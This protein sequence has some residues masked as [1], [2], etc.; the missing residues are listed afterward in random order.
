MDSLQRFVCQVRL[1]DAAGSQLGCG[2]IC[3]PRHVLTCTHVV[4]ACLGVPASLGADVSARFPLAPGHVASLQVRA[5]RPMLDVQRAETD[6]DQLHDLCLLELAKG[7]SFP[8]QAAAAIPKRGAIED[9]LPIYAL[10]L[11][12]LTTEEGG[13]SADIGGVD[14]KGE[15]GGYDSLS[16]RRLHSGDLETAVRHGCSGTAAFAAGGLI[17]MVVEKQE[18][19]TALIVPLTVLGGLWNFD[20]GA[21]AAGISARPL[22]TS[23]SPVDGSLLKAFE[24][25]DRIDQV[26]SFKMAFKNSWRMA[27]RA[28]MCTI[29]GFDLDL[30]LSCR[31]RLRL[32]LRPFLENQGFNFASF[33]FE[34]V[35]WPKRERFDVDQE[36]NRM[37]NVFALH[38]GTEESSPSAICNGLNDRLQPTAL[39][40][41]IDQRHWG[42][43]HMLLLRRWGDLLNEI[44]AHGLEKPCIHFVIL[45][46]DADEIA[47]TEEEPT[48]PLRRFYK[49]LETDVNERGRHQRLVRTDMLNDF[50][51]HHVKTWIEQVGGGMNLSD[52]HI[53]YLTQQ[54]RVS[55]PPDPLRLK[56]IEDWI[57]TASVRRG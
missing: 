29:A 28:L 45:Q 3:G 7:A 49:T 41:E 56:A 23:L 25:F 50:K 14:I 1:V 43:R 46:L 44:S 8:A 51:Y 21:P 48:G 38:A 27:S 18:S 55:L 16:R 52:D 47:S 5:F 9:D 2:F 33:V 40:S 24:E 15:L 20:L 57:Q 37:C 12:V 17:G 36:F 32:A 10:G 13:P 30:P 39:F 53:A 35:G 26:A 31:D 6:A 34:E 19:R 22:Q 42:K 54:A 4:E 11:G